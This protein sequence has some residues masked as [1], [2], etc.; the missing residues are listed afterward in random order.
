MPSSDTMLV[1]YAALLA[2]GHGRKRRNHQRTHAYAEACTD[3]V[4]AE[5]SLEELVALESR[6]D[7]AA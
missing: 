4:E 3:M 5:I 1:A 6:D 2:H 7:A